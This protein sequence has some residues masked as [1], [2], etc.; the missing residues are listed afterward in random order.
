MD[1]NQTECSNMFHRMGWATRPNPP[2]PIAPGKWAVPDDG[3][4]DLVVQRWANG[5]H[6]EVKNGDTSFAFSEWRENQRTWA[7]KYGDQH[8]LWFFLGLG[9]DP[10]NYNPEKYNPRGSF[11]F[12][13]WVMLI[14]EQMLLP[15]QKSLPYRA[16]GSL[17][18]IQEQRLYAEY[19]LKNYR[20]VWSDGGWHMPATN[21]FPL[22]PLPSY[23]RLISKETTN[24]DRSIRSE[25]VT[26]QT[27]VT[28]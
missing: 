14:C 12:P 3:S 20:L 16:K 8:N 15:Y 21:S 7:N 28:A 18:V 26:E 23:F 9:T 10:P 4:P 22:Q 13:W 2:R 1:K 24:G 25:P 17:I 19:L 27:R 5:A 11:L 6:I